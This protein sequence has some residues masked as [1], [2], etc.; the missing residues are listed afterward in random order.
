MLAAE[1]FRRLLSDLALDAAQRTSGLRAHRTV[2]AI[3]QS[4]Y[5]GHLTITDHSR[6][7]GA[8]AKGTDVRPPRSVD[9]LFVLPKS[10]R[11]RDWTSRSSDHPA[12]QILRDV[13]QV[14]TASDRRTR[15][16]PD[17][18]AIVVPVDGETVEVRPAFTLPGGRYQACH[19][20]DQGGFYTCDPSL[21]ESNLRQCDTRS[22]GN[23][24]DLIRMAKCWQGYRNVPIASFALELLAI[25]FLGS[26]VHAGDPASFYDWMIR[27]F[28]GFLAGQAARSIAIPGG[29]GTIDLGTAWLT[30]ARTAHLQASKACECESEGLNADAWW[31]WEKIFG[32]R[33]P[34]EA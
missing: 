14:L 34:L 33:V 16:R 3:L 6:L 27:D 26:W 11:E 9:L 19:A 18:L 25:E 32:E 7:I 8:W 30:A 4:H 31:E 29:E 17:G 23:G 15:L 28:F 24:R 2:R 13:D 10:L 21:E 5:Y 1:R 12:L 20:R 22:Q